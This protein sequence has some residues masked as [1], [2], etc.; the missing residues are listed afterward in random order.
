MGNSSCFNVLE[1]NYSTSLSPQ[2]DKGA[3]TDGTALGLAGMRRIKEKQIAL[4]ERG[5]ARTPAARLAAR[6]ANRERHPTSALRDVPLAGHLFTFS[7]SLSVAQIDTPPLQPAAPA[8][9]SYGFVLVRVR[10][11]RAN[12]QSRG[13]HHLRITSR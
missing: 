12:T 13:D 5:S 6:K 11:R 1:R 3:E 7:L 9:M 4:Y 8:F 2:S 10:V